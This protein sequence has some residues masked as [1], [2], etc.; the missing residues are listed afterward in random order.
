MAAYIISD[1]TIRDAQAIESYREHAAASIKQYGGRYLV[2]GGAVETLEGG[3]KPD[4]I[5]VVEFPDIASAKRWYGS[6]EYAAALEVRDSALTRNLIL[7]D[8]VAV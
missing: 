1:V 5:I 3:W 4:P 8:G 6:P 7:V 2:R